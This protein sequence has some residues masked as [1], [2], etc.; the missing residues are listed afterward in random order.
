MKRTPYHALLEYADIIPFLN[1][2]GYRFIDIAPRPY[3][4]KMIEREERE[5]V[6]GII[7]TL[8]AQYDINLVD[9]RNDTEKEFYK[10]LQQDY[11]VQLLRL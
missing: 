2:A 3:P 11:R 8:W 5:M 6:R 4:K 7:H 9:H 10:V 1:Y